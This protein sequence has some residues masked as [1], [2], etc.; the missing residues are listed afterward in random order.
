MGDAAPAL[1][2]GGPPPAAGQGS[3]GAAALPRPEPGV[4]RRPERPGRAAG[5]LP[6]GARH[7]RARGD[8]ARMPAAVRLLGA[9]RVAARYRAP[10]RDGSLL[11]QPPP[12]GIGP[13]P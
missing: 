6:A 3:R 8:P 7:G 10:A 9:V 13:L 12:P 11:P 1:G 4:R 5:L 2:A